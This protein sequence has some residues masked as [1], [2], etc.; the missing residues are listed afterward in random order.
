M[1]KKKEETPVTPIVSVPKIR[2]RII[3]GS[4]GLSFLPEV[5]AVR[6]RDIDYGLLVMEDFMPT[7][8]GIDG[9]I[10][11]LTPQGEVR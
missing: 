8:G 2:A 1:R 3:D 6:I 5:S 7:L 9:T 10:V 4:A 11:F